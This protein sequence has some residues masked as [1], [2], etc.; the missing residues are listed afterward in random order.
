MGFC[1]LID[2]Y[3]NFNFLFPFILIILIFYIIFKSKVSWYD[4]INRKFLINCP[5]SILLI[6]SISKFSNYI[7]TFLIFLLILIFLTLQNLERQAPPLFW[8]D[9]NGEFHPINIPN[10]KLDMKNIRENH[11][12]QFQAVY[13]VGLRNDTIS[14]NKFKLGD[15]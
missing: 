8:K 15:F 13:T 4:Y 10:I 6:G 3:F 9:N 11:M 7:L 5:L 12:T 1:W 2:F 14:I